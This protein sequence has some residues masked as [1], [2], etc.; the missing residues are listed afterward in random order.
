MNTRASLPHRPPTLNYASPPRLPP[1][2]VA[3]AA[4]SGWAL[5]TTFAIPV[6]WVTTGAG[7]S[8][9]GVA[10]LRSAS[11]LFLLTWLGVGL[12]GPGLPL[13]LSIYCWRH[14]S[15]MIDADEGGWA[16]HMGFFAALLSSLEVL[17]GFSLFAV[18]AG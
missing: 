5:L 11:T 6:L 7:L 2:S 9:L 14:V 1:E 4:R 16:F 12:I 17:M 10:E 15:R 3:R 13:F 18:F 8:M